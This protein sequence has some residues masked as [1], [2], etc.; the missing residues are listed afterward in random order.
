M[1]H[2]RITLYIA[3]LLCV[4]VP[5]LSMATTTEQG[6]ALDGVQA[7][8]RLVVGNVTPVTGHFG[9]EFF[10]DDTSDLDVRTLL[11]DYA[12]VEWE[13]A[14]GETPHTAAVES[15]ETET[16]QDGSHLYTV[17]LANNLRYNDGTPI[18]AQDYVF[19]LLLAASP[20][21]R[22]VGGTLAPIEHIVG[23]DEYMNG[24]SQTLSGVRLLSP[25]QFSIQILSDAPHFF[26]LSQVSIPPYPIKVIAPGCEAADDGGGAYLR[27]AADA[28]TLQGNGYTPGEFGA[29]MLRVTL[30]DPDIGYESNPR[31]TSGPYQLDAYDKEMGTVNFTVN[32]NFLGN[33]I[34]KMPHIERLELRAVDGGTMIDA[35]KSGEIDLLNK[36]ASLGALTAAQQ[37][38]M[39]DPDFTSMPYL[40][41]GLALLSFSCEEGVSASENVRKAVGMSFDKD[42]M[43]A[44][45]MG[46][47]A[48]KVNG[49]YGLGQ[50]MAGYASNP[51]SGGTDVSSRLAALEIPKDIEGARQLLEA[52]GWTLG[53]DGAPYTDGIRYRQGEQ[54]LEPLMI[55]LAV[56]R[57]NDARDA[58]AQMLQVSLTE[59]GAG[60]EVS[61]LPFDELLTHYYRQTDRVYDMFYLATNFK[62]PFDPYFDFH[63]ADAFQGAANKTGLRDDSLMQLAHTTRVMDPNDMEAYMEAWV[64]FQERLMEL[65]PL[66]PLYSG[67]YIDAYTSRLTGY[68]IVAHNGW[69]R[70]VQE[71]WIAE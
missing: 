21:L 27:R 16:Q 25:N 50:W 68:S 8:T 20:A 19:S 9:T 63:T 67:V 23:F 33:N 65:Q 14:P 31:V 3:A 53:E 69:A 10:G 71:A 1:R 62:Y 70:A 44:A 61:V 2:Q 46:E 17:T 26:I 55:R 22:E 36:V 57:E 58:L 32:P 64:A 12:I 40:R 47:L 56:P 35:L 30:L 37:L 45:L 28:D 24:Q 7:G 11:H 29:Q 42:E 43:V 51:T 4:C 59:I 54:G 15:L 52:D 66:I 39:D 49:Y 13:K 6:A 41:S 48:R 60:L 34:G 38:A 18:T 5:S